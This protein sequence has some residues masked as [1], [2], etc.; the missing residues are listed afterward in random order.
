MSD[1]TEQTGDDFRD[2]AK[3]V[4]QALLMIV[5]YLEKRYVL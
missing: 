2:F 4:R 1:Q 3:V 5:K